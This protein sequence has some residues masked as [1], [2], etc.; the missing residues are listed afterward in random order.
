MKTFTITATPLFKEKEP[1]TIQKTFEFDFKNVT[2]VYR[3]KLNQC[4]CGCGGT[5]LYTNDEADRFNV[6]R[7]K[8]FIKGSDKAILNDLQ[9]F[10]SGKYNVGFCEDEEELR[11]EFISEIRERETI[12]DEWDEEIGVTLYIKK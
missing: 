6:G 3:G 9:K 10:I 7:T 2:S 11:L 12:Y 8:N 5:Y 1:F 4:R